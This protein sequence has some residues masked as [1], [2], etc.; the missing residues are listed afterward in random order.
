ME[1]GRVF[2]YRR[3]FQEQVELAGPGGVAGINEPDGDELA[4]VALG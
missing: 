4:I 3:P 2:L 1:S